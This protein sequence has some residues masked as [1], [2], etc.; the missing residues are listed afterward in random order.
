MIMGSIA[1]KD[2]SGVRLGHIFTDIQSL[3]VE[4]T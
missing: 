2:V 3:L 1:K 4:L